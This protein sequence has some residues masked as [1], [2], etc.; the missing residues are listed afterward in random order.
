MS[1]DHDRSCLNEPAAICFGLDRTTDEQSLAALLRRFADD[2]LLATLVPRLEAA[3]IEA[4]V[5]LCTGLLQRHLNHREYH[6][7]FLR[8]PGE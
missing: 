1:R 2:N 6:R 4:M 5:Q 3:E 8:Q 7:L